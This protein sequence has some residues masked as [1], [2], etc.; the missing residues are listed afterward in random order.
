MEREAEQIVCAECGGP[1]TAVEIPAELQRWAGIVRPVCATCTERLE[2]EDRDRMA[3]EAE[4]HRAQATARRLRSVGVPAHLR[5]YG[6]ADIDQ[7]EGL[8][9]ALEL[10]R[11]WAAGELPGLGFVGPNGTG[12]SRVSVAAANEACAR[13]RVRWYSAPVLIARLGS[14]GFDSPERTAA[15]EA[16]MGTGPL[17]LDDLDKARPTEY[18]AEALFTAIDARVDG[19]GQLL[20]TTNLNGAELAQRWAQ[21]Y[22]AALADR[23]QLLKWHRVQGESKR[24]SGSVGGVDRR[25]K[26]DGGE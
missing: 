10:A 24:A 21:P 16:L 22:G 3:A 23:L 9:R 11:A 19:G 14:G 20:V 18:A 17:V 26:R 2:A 13:A 4:Q 1:T 15:L 7:P 8:E 5:G 6:F 25:L 12:K